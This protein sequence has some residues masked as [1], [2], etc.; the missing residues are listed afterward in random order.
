MKTRRFLCASIEIANHCSTS[1]AKL[2][3]NLKCRAMQL[4]AFL[5]GLCLIGPVA[6]ASSCS[7]S[8]EAAVDG[9]VRREVVIHKTPLGCP[10]VFKSYVSH[11]TEIEII[12]G[13]TASVTRAPTSL[14]TTLFP[15]ED[16]YNTR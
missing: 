16:I 15:T 7:A 6:C 8:R 4:I 2:F 13:Y 9:A 5:Q 11:R 10:V 1:F 12:P 14:V 3:A